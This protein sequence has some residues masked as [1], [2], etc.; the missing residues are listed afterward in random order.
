MLSRAL[1]L[2]KSIQPDCTFK[3]KRDMVEVSSVKWSVPIDPNLSRQAQLLCNHVVKDNLV[4]KDYL[5]HC[6]N[7]FLLAAVSQNAKPLKRLYG[8]KKDKLIYRRYILL[9][10]TKTCQLTLTVWHLFSSWSQ[11]DYRIVTLDKLDIY[12]RFSECI[13]KSSV[14]ARCSLNECSFSANVSSFFRL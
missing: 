11:T 13:V 10:C 7:S 3:G 9:R 1:H 14:V 8:G 2:F 6:C 5:S 12:I 4:W